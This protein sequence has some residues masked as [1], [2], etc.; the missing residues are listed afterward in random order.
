[1]E[2]D[3]QKRMRTASWQK[4][5]KSTMITRVNKCDDLDD[6]NDEDNTIRS[7][8]GED[9]GQMR[10]KKKQG[11]TFLS[12]AGFFSIW[13]LPPTLTLQTFTVRLAGGEA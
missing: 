10:W 5:E 11:F 8:G 4:M 3:Q 12:L 6:E 1:M 2:N 7:E 9:D 13:V